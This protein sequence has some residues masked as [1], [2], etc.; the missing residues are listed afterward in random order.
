M[1]RLM[2]DRHPDVAI[3]PE[4][5]FIPELYRRRRRYGR[6]GRVSRIDPFVRDLQAHH[7]FREWELPL[8]AVRQELGRSG[9]DL[10][11]GRAFEAVFRAYAAALG[12]PRWGDKTPDYVDDLP[13]LARLFPTARFVHLIR[14]G[15]DVAL[16]VL[17]LRHLHRHAA[18][19]AFFWGRQIRAARAAAAALPGRY[20]E[21]RY[22]RLVADPEGELRALCAFLDLPFEQ[23]ML[24]G[25]PRD[26]ERIP[27]GRRRLHSAAVTKPREGVRDWRRDMSRAEVEE[28]EAVA[29]R[30]LSA[31]GYEPSTRPGLRARLR[32]RAR[33]G[34]F[35]RLWLRRLVRR[36]RRGS[37]RDRAGEDA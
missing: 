31:T 15:R 37:R 2:L 26:R 4:S 5:H 23:A 28:F 12:K 27:A 19:V 21:V 25:D 1:L 9:E 8:D 3:P 24:R 29:A 18:S 16:S 33:L 10:P 30:D 32:A 20:L 7:R 11:L 22:E 35:A 36:A 17:D 34:G 6:G 14:D 13:L